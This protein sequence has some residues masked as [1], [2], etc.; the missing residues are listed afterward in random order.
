[1]T[2]TRN[3]RNAIRTHRFALKRKGFS[4]DYLIREQ[5]VGSSNLPAPTNDFNNLEIYRERRR[6][7]LR[8]DT[9]PDDLPNLPPHMKQMAGRQLASPEACATSEN[10]SDLG[11]KGGGDE[12]RMPS[13]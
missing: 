3:E 13:A 1:M 11:V 10:T 4:D 2:R 5:G 9:W 12:V 6:A 8:A 7:D